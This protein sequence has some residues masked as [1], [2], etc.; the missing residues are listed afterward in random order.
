MVP[1]E[2]ELLLIAKIGVVVGTIVWGV[3]KI[4]L[5]SLEKRLK[6]LESHFEKEGWIPRMYE[7]VGSQE[8]KIEHLRSIV[9][10]TNADNTVVSR[11]LLNPEVTLPPKGKSNAR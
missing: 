10:F 1:V 7:R 8:T 5:H 9:L 6:T 4:V 2:E 11:S 3:L